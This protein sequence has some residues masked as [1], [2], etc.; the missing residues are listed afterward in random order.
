MADLEH[1][2]RKTP[3]GPLGAKKEVSF[4]YRILDFHF[5]LL[6]FLLMV[7]HDVTFNVTATI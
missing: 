2:W 1:F 5:F 7:M 6:F 3:L 4:A